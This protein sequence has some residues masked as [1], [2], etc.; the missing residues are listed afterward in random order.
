[1]F[2]CLMWNTPKHQL[3]VNCFVSYASAELVDKK[4]LKANP[5]DLFK[6]ILA[7]KEV[8]AKIGPQVGAKKKGVCVVM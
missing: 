6:A 2:F 5:T 7:Y 4:E 3:I 1:M 8:R